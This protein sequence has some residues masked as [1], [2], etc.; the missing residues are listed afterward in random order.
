[1][2]AGIRAF[3]AQFVDGFRFV[4]RGFAMFEQ[5]GVGGT[6]KYFHGNLSLWR[7]LRHKFSTNPG[8]GYNQ[9]MFKRRLRLILTILILSISLILLVWGLWPFAGVTRVLSFPAGSLVVP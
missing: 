4:V 5:V 7:G 9:S 8:R 6:E 2:Q 1:M 3:V